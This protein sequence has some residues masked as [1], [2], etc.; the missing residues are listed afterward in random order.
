MLILIALVV[1]ALAQ[2]PLSLKEYLEQPIPEEAENLSGEAFAEFLNK[3][4]SFFT[5]KYT[6]NALNIL[7]MRVMESRFLD[8]EEGE[9]LKEEDMDFSEEI[10]VSFDARDKWPK[11]TSIGF[12]RDQSHCGSCW[13]VSSAETMSDRLCV[14]SNGTIKVTS[15]KKY[16]YPIRTSL[17]VAR[18]VVLGRNYELGSLHFK[19]KNIHF[20]DVEEATQF[21]RG[22][23]LRTQAFALADYMEQR[24]E[25]SD[26][27]K[28]YAFY[29]CKDESYGKCPKDSFP[30]PKCRKI[31]Q[32]KYSKK[33]ADDKYYANSAY[34][35]PQNETWIKLEIMRNGPVTAS[36]RIY[37]D[38]GF[39]EKGVYVTSG[40]R[41]LGG[42]AIK[43]IGWGTE[44]VNGT[45]LPYWL[46]ANSWGTDWGENN[47]YF[48]I[49]R[50]QN[51]CQIEQ[52]V[53]A[54]MIKVPQPKSAGPPLQPNPSS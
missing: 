47:G 39:Y 9:M 5:A 22:N 12:I 53:I 49:L 16:F 36:F 31:C 50:G 54:G 34:R 40:G 24:Q 19:K 27:C 15:K 46:I 20:L 17:P 3:R 2:Q 18:I 21:E 41:E 1:T 7:K 26:S 38:F 23:I 44:K 25:I 29:P 14:Q 33:Y 51:H 6:P 10:P 4:Q 45:D 52:K 13:A 37:P 8:N 48:R 42:H 35:I 11:C 43:I 28:P 32:Y 30:T